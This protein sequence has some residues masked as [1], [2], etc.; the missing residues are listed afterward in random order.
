MPERS[1]DEDE[2]KRHRSAEAWVEATSAFDRVMS[3]ALSVDEPK[4]TA[5]IADEA[6]VAETTARSHLERL[7]DLHVLT[8]AT[9]H[10]PTTYSPD[11]GYLRFRR[12]SELVEERDKD[13]IVKYVA[14]L[15][16]DI[17]S[18]K[19]EYG[20]AGPDEL[21][22]KATDDDVSAEAAREFMQVASEWD[23]REREKSIVRE[24]IQ[25]YDQFENPNHEA[26][27]S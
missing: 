15:K 14:E 19:D 23:S 9:T 5:W 21:R 16:A 8:S 6:H 3:V 27:R 17:E 4:T 12:V 22:M 11:A 7:V 20:V 2:A 26:M 1:T 10:G 13:E 24:A 25:R 18:W